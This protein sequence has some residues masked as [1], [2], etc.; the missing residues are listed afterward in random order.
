MVHIMVKH[1]VADYDK[2]RGM[3]DSDKV[4]RETA[5]QVSEQVFR[6][7]GDPSEVVLLF[8]WDTVEKINEFMSSDHLKQKMQEAGVTSQPEITLLDK[9]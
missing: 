6:S 4:A 8:E 1:K 3:F 2:W 9:V 7:Q 5:G